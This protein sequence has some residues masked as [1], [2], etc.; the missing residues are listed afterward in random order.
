[1]S[2]TGRYAEGIALI[3]R[4]LL[5]DPLSA[6][7]YSQLARLQLLTGRLDEARAAFEKIREL[8]PDAPGAQANF[9]Y[10]A[11]M[12]GD[13]E[14]A[15]RTARMIP[16][17]K[18]HDDALAFAAQV[19]VDRAAADAALHAYIDMQGARNPSGVAEMYALRNEPGP[20]FDWLER[21]L[22][23]G[24]PGAKWVWED[25]HLIRYRSDPRFVAY[26]RKAGIPTPAEVDAA[27]AAASPAKQGKPS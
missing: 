12:R 21:A 25:P 3:R 8:L 2:Q 22:A 9:V 24:D 13:A 16:P 19:G 4:S 17:G 20:M 14:A 15:M 27:N 18:P 26:C 1:M 7:A 10:L 5:S 6:V 23:A 11:M